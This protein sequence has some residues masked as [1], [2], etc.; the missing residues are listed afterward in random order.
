MESNEG[1]QAR[2]LRKTEELAAYREDHEDT[3][4]LD[5]ARRKCGRHLKAS[6]DPITA[7]FN[8]L[9]KGANILGALWEDI[10]CGTE[11]PSGLRASEKCLHSTSSSP[12]AAAEGGGDGD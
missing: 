12:M 4:K 6:K 11:R 9:A 7:P 3:K 10:C 8:R 5:P 1:E 2:L